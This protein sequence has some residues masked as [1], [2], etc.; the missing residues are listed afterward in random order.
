MSDLEY[1]SKTNPALG[2]SDNGLN[3]YTNSNTFSGSQQEIPNPLGF[4]EPPSPE[5]YIQRDRLA[6]RGPEAP[7]KGYM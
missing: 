4:N 6:P 5:D 1:A 2:L 3:E 7:P